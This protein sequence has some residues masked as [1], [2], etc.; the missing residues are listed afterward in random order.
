MGGPQPLME[1]KI[2]DVPE[3]NYLHTDKDKNG[4]SSPRGELWVRGPSIIPEYFLLEKETEEA[5]TQDGWL[6][7][8]DVV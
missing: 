3:M 6:K 1:F 5:I 7:T 4:L 2:M 8:G